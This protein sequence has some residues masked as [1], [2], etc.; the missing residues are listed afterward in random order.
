MWRLSCDAQHEKRACEASGAPCGGRSRYLPSKSGVF[1]RP[2]LLI[3]IL[4]SLWF[5][6]SALA[7]VQSGDARLFMDTDVFSYERTTIES[8]GKKEIDSQFNLGPGA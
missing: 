8:V 2:W 4:S 1:V 3:P 7:Q 5:A 6:S